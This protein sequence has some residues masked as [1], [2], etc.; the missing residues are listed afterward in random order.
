VEE[1]VGRPTTS[2]RT[3]QGREGARHDQTRQEQHGAP[4]HPRDAPPHDG[5]GPLHHHAREAPRD[6]EHSRYRGEAHEPEQDGHQFGQEG[7]HHQGQEA[8]PPPRISGEAFGGPQGKSLLHHFCEQAALQ[9]QSLAKGEQLLVT[10]QRAGHTEDSLR[11]LLHQEQPQTQSSLQLLLVKALSCLSGVELSALNVNVSELLD[12]TVSYFMGSGSSRFNS[13]VPLVASHPL[14]HLVTSSTLLAPSLLGLP[15]PLEASGFGPRHHQ[16]HVPVRQESRGF[17][18]VQDSQ[19]FSSPQESL[20]FAPQ[21]DH[22]GFGNL[23]PATFGA[24]PPATFGQ[25]RRAEEAFP[26]P[27]YPQ[28]LD[29]PGVTLSRAQDI[30]RALD[31]NRGQDMARALDMTRGQDSARALDTPVFGLPRPEMARV[32]GMEEAME[33]SMASSSRQ[34]YRGRH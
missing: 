21:P 3:G 8:P 31:M 4:R 20:G 14:A 1:G 13:A 7:H 18:A 11:R 5:R 29:F 34:D 10:W 25:P 16:G 24:P 27:G 12:Q 17:A 15:A 23:P 19:S 28:G 6:Q 9:G 26:A 30:A 22:R 2:T 32:Q 33:V